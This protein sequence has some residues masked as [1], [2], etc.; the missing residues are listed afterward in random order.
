MDRRALIWERHLELAVEAGQNWEREAS[1]LEKKLERVLVRG[2]SGADTPR[3]VASFVARESA[4]TALKSIVQND[5]EFLG[6]ER[7]FGPTLD[8]E[9][10]A[11]SARA[12]QIGFS[13]ARLVEPQGPGVV[14]NGFATGFLV[15]PRLLMTNWHVFRDEAEATGT[16]AQFGYEYRGA[17]LQ[18]G[19]QFILRPDLY[20]YANRELDLAL[21]AVSTTSTAGDA[22]SR[23]NFIRL[24]PTEGKILMGHQVHMI[25]HPEGQPKT[26]VSKNNPLVSVEAL[27]LRYLTDSD[28]GGSG[29]PAFNPQWELVAL[30]HRAV[31]RTVNGQPMRKGGTPWR[32]GDPSDDIDWVANEGIRVSVIVEHLRQASGAAGSYLEELLTLAR[33][34]IDIRAAVGAVQAAEGE[35]MDDKRTYVAPGG[36]I[37]LNFSGPV[38]IYLNAPAPL[39][40]VT[41]PR[42]TESTESAELGKEVAIRFDPRYS[43]RTGY[44]QD[45]LSG[46]VVPPPKTKIAKLGE[47]LRDAN[48]EERVLHYRHFSLAMHQER[49]LQMWSAMNASY[50]AKHRKW[51]TDRNSFGND[52]WIP[53]PRLPAD[54]QLMDPQIYQPS[55]SLQ[56]GHIVRR[57]DNAWGYDKADQE[58]ANS[59]TFHWTNCT[60]QHGGFNEAGYDIPGTQKSYKGIW[61]A[62]ENKIKDL[63]DSFDEQ[64]M[65]IFAG[66]ILAEGDDAYDWGLGPIQVPMRY[67]KVVIGVEQ[68]ELS[69]YGFILDQTKAFEDLGFERLNFGEFNKKGV[70]LVQIGNEAGIDFAQIILDADVLAGQAVY[71]IPEGAEVR[72]RARAA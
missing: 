13:V 42:T 58:Y 28:E 31:P 59:D 67:W 50:A 49:R 17:L 12:Q 35:S 53:D 30:H 66:P 51:F 41:V 27:T 43:Q 23:F 7:R 52:K 26:Y 34:P 9:Y 2:P 16:A 57:D 18:E 24:I 25:G 62:L 29:S 55:L 56:R 44:A 14:P 5:P 71:E 72:K 36:P 39:P 37:T 47:V 3:R 32:K 20:F 40:Q 33:D 6:M 8:Y 70:P 69:A 61:G 68:G 60:P 45:F 65:S 64:R 1:K 38:T 15:T 46:F 10:V 48:E 21:V 19:L 63:V 22:L 4:R 11:P 54:A